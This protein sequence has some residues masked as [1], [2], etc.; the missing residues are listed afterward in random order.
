VELVRSI[1]ADWER[2]DY[3]SAEWA[4]PD[5]RAGADQSVTSSA[6]VELVRSIYATWRRGET[7]IDVMAADVVWDFSRR[8]VEPEIYRGREGV[9]R[10]VRQL[11]EAWSE[12]RQ[13][14]SE[15]IA[16]GERVLVLLAIEG[17]GRASG[18][19][20]D[21]RIAHIWTLRD[22]QVASL[23]Y[24]GDVAEAQRALRGA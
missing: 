2:G 6:N 1:C 18:A 7:A 17:R 12:L 13:E 3:T 16:A 20:V 23:E 10:F 21:E 19:E 24:F 14:P 22:G 15:Y 5:I 9:R 11:F 8:Q 4:H